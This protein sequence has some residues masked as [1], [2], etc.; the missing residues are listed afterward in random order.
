MPLHVD[1]VHFSDGSL[2]SQQLHIE[3]YC[4]FVAIGLKIALC[5]VGGVHAVVDDHSWSPVD[6]SFSRY[7]YF[8]YDDTSIPHHQGQT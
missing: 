7:L 5:H 4:L 6:T 1:K 8:V 3:L 2:F